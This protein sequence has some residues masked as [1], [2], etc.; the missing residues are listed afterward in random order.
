MIRR[1][2]VKGRLG[3]GRVRIAVRQTSACGHGCSGCS[4]CTAVGP[5]RE[6]AAVAEDPIGAHA[7]QQ[8]T[9]EQVSGPTV[10]CAFLLY[11][12]PFV[13]LLGAAVGL[14]RFGE[15]I[16]ALGAVAVF[17]GLLVGAAVPLERYLRRH[18]AVT[19]RVV[20]VEG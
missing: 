3:P 18:W 9:V 1:A 15:G 16:A 2:V 12:L 8:V 14:S 13:G 10:R 5:V 7:G 20:A 6:I 4:G 19:Y 11:L 17:L